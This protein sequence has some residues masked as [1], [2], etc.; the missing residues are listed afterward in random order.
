MH[1]SYRGGRPSGGPRI[2]TASSFVVFAALAAGGGRPSGGPRIATASASGDGAGSAA[3]RSPLGGTEDRNTRLRACCAW[4]RREWRSP[5]GGTEDCN[6]FKWKKL[7]VPAFVAVALRDDRGSQLPG[8]GGDVDSLAE[9]RSPLGT[10]ED[11]NLDDVLFEGPADVGWRSSFGT[12]EDRNQ[13]RP[14]TS[15]TRTTVA[16]V[17]RDDRGSQHQE[18]RPRRATG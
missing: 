11:R 6:L 3:W 16:V 15:R 5:L 8:G 9:W 4:R 13:R 18:P 1:L 12:T 10:T 14:A 7:I 2:A 17:L